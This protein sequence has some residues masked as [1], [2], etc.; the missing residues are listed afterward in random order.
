[1]RE[2]G[3]KML[4]VSL[5]LSLM[6]LPSNE[7]LVSHVYLLAHASLHIRMLALPVYSTSFQFFVIF[8]FMTSN[9][10]Y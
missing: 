7:L 8:I 6:L 9:I 5:Y 2:L 3:R 1:M 4:R 10:I